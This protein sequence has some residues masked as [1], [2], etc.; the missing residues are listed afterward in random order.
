MAEPNKIPQRE[1]RLDEVLGAYLDAQDRGEA[2]T[3][4]ELL[5]RHPAL[6]DDLRRFFA[7]EAEFQRR[8]AALRE[9]WRR[10]GQTNGQGESK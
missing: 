7:D 1:Q 8:V 6:V 3:L 5:A 10:A 9:A 2:P 4:A